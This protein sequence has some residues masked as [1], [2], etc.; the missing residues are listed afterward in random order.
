MY[1]IENKKIMLQFC[2]SLDFKIFG[3]TKEKWP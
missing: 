1:R 3:V 2:L